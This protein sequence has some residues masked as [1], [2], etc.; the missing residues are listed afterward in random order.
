MSEPS[1]TRHD[2]SSLPV[3]NTPQPLVNV[4]KGEARRGDT[5]VEVK[6][7]LSLRPPVGESVRRIPRQPS[8]HDSCL[9]SYN[10][11]ALL[12]RTLTAITR[13]WLQAT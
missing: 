12:A 7:V 5:E 11:S 8:L 1:D 3:Y 9:R 4:M 10:Y 13:A 6:L 2:T